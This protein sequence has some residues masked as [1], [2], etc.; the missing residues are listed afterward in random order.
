MQLSSLF[1]IKDLES[2]LY[3]YCVPFPALRLGFFL[4]DRPGDLP[5]AILR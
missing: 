5:R 4:G 1:G 2:S 3:N